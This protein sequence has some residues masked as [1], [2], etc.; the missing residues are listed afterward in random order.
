MHSIF[1]SGA[2][3]GI[4]AAIATLFYQHGYKVGIYDINLVQ[5]Q[6]LAQQLG[7]QAK[8]GLLDV[9]NYSQWQQALSE[10]QAWAGE[11]NVLVNNAGILYSGAFEQTDITAHHR[12]IDINVKGVLNGCHAALPFLKQ[13][14][15]ARVINLSS[16]SAIYGQADLVSYSASKFAV[17]GITEGLDI[18]WQKYGIRVLDVMPLFVQTAMV[19]DMDAGSIQNMGVHLSA[20]DV[21]KQIY[22][23]VQRQ[24]SIFTPTHQLVGFK[25]KLL[26]TL[27][28]MSPQFVNRISNRILAKRK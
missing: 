26:F 4:G 3:Q 6:K 1:I 11:L 23:L 5:A 22:Q 7:P 9:S 16:A 14:S 28:G 10:F 15:F 13:A 20:H 25:T 27:S 24:D 19:K 18:E 21:A 2:A 17:R 8:A 12:T